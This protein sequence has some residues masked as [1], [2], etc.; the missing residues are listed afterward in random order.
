VVVDVVVVTG[1]VVGAAPEK[2]D[3]P[4]NPLVPENPDGPE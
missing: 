4:E 3:V 2:P 1:I